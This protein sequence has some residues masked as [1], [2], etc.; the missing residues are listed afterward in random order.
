MGRMPDAIYQ[1]KSMGMRELA[2]Q[3]KVWAINGIA[4]MAE[5]PLFSVKRGT[6]IN[7]EVLN[8]NAWPHGIHVHGHHFID[9]R[10]PGVWRD[11]ALLNRMESTK[12]KFVA[13]N[14]GD[15]LIHCHMLEHQAA[16]MKTWF[17]VT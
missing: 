6:A 15:W 1:G 17:R 12:L 2:Q 8:N 3:G 16:G 9:S 5:Q 4:D 11:T 14:P 13:D 7:L 10:E